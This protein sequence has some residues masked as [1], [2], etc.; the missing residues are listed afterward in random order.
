MDTAGRV[1]ASNIIQ[2]RK[3]V[4]LFV[5]YAQAYYRLSD[6]NGAL[7]LTNFGGEGVRV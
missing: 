1:K 7:C 4:Y 6:Y 3:L 5:F 2:Q